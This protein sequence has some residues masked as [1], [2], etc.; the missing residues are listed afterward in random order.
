MLYLGQSSLQANMWLSYLYKL[1]CG[2]AFLYKGCLGLLIYTTSLF[3]IGL[4]NLA[5]ECKPAHRSTIIFCVGSFG[6]FQFIVKCF[7]IMI[8]L[9]IVNYFH[10]LI[11][12]GISMKNH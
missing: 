7:D 8:S 2:V 11:I 4:C 9:C 12:I 3:S 1:I 6:Y 5:Y 10:F